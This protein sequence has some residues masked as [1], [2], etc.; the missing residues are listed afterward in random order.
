MPAMAQQ[1][2]LP[3]PDGSMPESG[4][5]TSDPAS[6]PVEASAP[7]AGD[8]VDPDQPELPMPGVPALSFPGLA[9]I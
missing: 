1:T 5:S 7:P 2:P 4:T 3:F 8:A 9:L 6:T